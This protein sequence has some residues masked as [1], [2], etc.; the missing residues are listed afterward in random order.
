MKYLSLLLLVLAVGAL[1][2]LV[3]TTLS[4]VDRNP[5]QLLDSARVRMSVPSPDIELALDDLELALSGAVEDGDDALAAEILIERSDIYRRLKS[6]QKAADDLVKV[7]ETYRPGDPHLLLKMLALDLASEEYERGLVRAGE[8]LD[9][10]PNLTQAWTYRG[11]FLVEVAQQKIDEAEQHLADALP[12]EQQERALALVHRLTGMEVGDPRRIALLLELRNLFREQNESKAR[13]VHRLV[14]LASQDLS[15][16]RDALAESFRAGIEREAAIEYLSILDQAGY[17]QEALDLGRILVRSR[18]VQRSPLAM[19]LLIEL[20]T[21]AGRASEACELMENRRGGQVQLSAKFL[22][23]WCRALYAAE[24]WDRLVAIA[25][26]LSQAART[27]DPALTSLAEFYVGVSYAERENWRQASVA[28]KT[29]MRSKDL[30][31]LV[32]RSG[33]LMWRAIAKAERERGKLGAELEALTEATRRGP[34]QSAAAWERLADVTLLVD[35]DDLWTAEVAFAHALRL[36]AD[37]PEETRR[38]FEAV[39]RKRLAQSG[40][41]VVLMADSLERRSLCVPA[42][43]T[44]PYELVQLIDLWRSRGDWSCVLAAAERLLESHPQFLPAMDAALEASLSLGNWTDVVAR[45]LARIR[46]GDLSDIVLRALEAIPGEYLSPRDRLKMMQFDPTGTGRL[47]IAAQLRASGQQRRALG[48]L[49]SMDPERLGDGGRVLAGELMLSI[50]LY[51]EAVEMLEPIARDSEAHAQALPLRVRAAGLAQDSARFRASLQELSEEPDIDPEPMLAIVDEMWLTGELE[52]AEALLT[53]LDTHDEGRTPEGMLRLGMAALL[54]GDAL[55]ASEHFDRNEAFDASGNPALGRLLLAIDESDWTRLP[56]DV[57]ALRSTGFEPT[58][59]AHAAVTLLDERLD[60]G[61]AMVEQ[62][63][64]DFEDEPL[65]SLLLAAARAMRIEVIEGD[66]RFGPD[67]AD[68]LTRLLYGKPAGSRNPRQ[69][70]GLVVALETEG[71]T[72]WS[73]VR[74]RRL[75]RRP[76]LAPWPAYLAARGLWSLDRLQ[77]TR[78][79]LRSL[80]DDHPSFGPAWDLLEEVETERL[81]RFDHIELVRLRQDRR[82]ALGARP[83]EEAELALERAFAL[84]S[85]GRI[86]EA[87]AAAQEAVDLDPTHLPAV[88]QLAQLHER[89]GAWREALELHRESVLKAPADLADE[90]VLDFLDFLERAHAAAPDLVSRATIAAELELLSRARPT[91]PL[92]ALARAREKLGE[93]SSLTALRVRRAYDELDAFRVA[94]EHRP[95]D[96]LR[97]GATRAWMEFYLELDPGAAHEF[98]RRERD[99]LPGH[100]DLWLMF[101]ETLVATG[102]PEAAIEHYRLVLE[103]LPEAQTRRHLVRLLARYGRD[104]PEIERHASAVAKIEGR[105]RDPEMALHRARALISDVG[106]PRAAGIE[107]LEELYSKPDT[108]GTVSHAEVGRMLGTGLVLRGAPKDLRRAAKVLA[109]AIPGIADPIQRNVAQAL[110]HLASG[111]ARP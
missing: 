72:A 33:G 11:R 94:T 62:G 38:R 106:K 110:Q 54:R 92:V 95:L 52:A 109:E 9:R 96:E 41:S 111:Q 107:L 84:E 14:D 48:G 39:G 99:R 31:P 91:D 81:G 17:E 40:T 10:D 77:D 1:A 59:R 86:A 82:E 88:E 2:G 83:G 71:W 18:D 57:T 89:T 36:G 63:L 26:Q 78:R 5:T 13:A 64:L 104:L 27:R 42:S 22:S 19:Q 85:Q 98:V 69:V 68:V 20:M 44:G 100:I 79:S 105:V 3:R 4:H 35:P 67:S 97:P 93:K 34:N 55:A 76:E 58:R 50:G 75:A 45:V 74:W 23:T 29:A 28:F 66:D 60:E 101:G 47:E 65:W 6:H 46:A 21:E 24:R 90:L 108:L 43:E 12:N 37:D 15:A 49:V 102:E 25:S 73:V 70:L 87:V 80:R 30:D 8:L 7:L 61:L 16:A 32:Q 53:T 103:M 56:S 51:S